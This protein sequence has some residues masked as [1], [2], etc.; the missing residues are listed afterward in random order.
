MES[1][2]LDFAKV[3]AALK[4]DVAPS[5]LKSYLEGSTCPKT[6][7]DRPGADAEANCQTIA[8]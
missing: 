8:D 6:N 5:E 3:L 7:V 1:W 2:L 4:S